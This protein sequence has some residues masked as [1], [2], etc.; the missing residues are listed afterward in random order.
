MEKLKV[1]RF[2]F[3]EFFLNASKPCLILLKIKGKRELTSKLR[4]VS[5]FLVVFLTNLLK[6]LSLRV[7]SLNARTSRN[8]LSRCLPNKPLILH[9]FCSHTFVFVTRAVLQVSF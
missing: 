4:A 2:Y 3:N 5:G 6:I 7:A 1:I 8:G 9:F